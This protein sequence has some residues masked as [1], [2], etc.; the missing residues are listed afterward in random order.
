MTKKYMRFIRGVSTNAYGKTGVILTTSAAVSFFLFEAARLVGFFH[1]SYVGL[2]SYLLFPAVFLAGLALIPFGWYRLRKTT[3]RSTRELLATSFDKTDLEG[4]IFGSNVFMTIALLSLSNVIILGG[5]TT[6]MLSFMDEA[7]FCGTACHVM[8]PEWTVYQDSPHARVKC[9]ECH[10]GEGVDALISSK[11]NGMRQ[12]FLASFSIYNR[13]IPTPVHT[14]RPARET[15]E[16]CHWPDKFYGS[17][18]VNKV[19]YGMDS[20]S[21]PAYTTLNLKVD[22]GYAGNKAGI[23]WH[24]AKENEVRYAALGKKREKML[25]VDVRQPDGS[26][27][28]FV[29][30]RY[31]DTAEEPEEVR[32]LDCVDCHNRA[33]HIYELP[34]HE[35]DRLIERGMLDRSLPFIKRESLAALI[36]NYPDDATAANNIERHIAE[37]YV[38]N[39]R[40][41]TRGNLAAVDRA[42]TALQDVYARNVHHEMNIEWGTYVNLLGHQHRDAGCFRCHNES[43]KADDGSFIRNDCT[44]CHSILSYDEPEPFRYLQPVDPDDKNAA[45][46]QY[47]REEFLRGR[48]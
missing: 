44:L 17:R 38:R 8:N 13:P 24:V 48:K 41:E 1:N 10:V 14:L 7:E 28:R 11:L 40:D 36:K 27:R 22:A 33:T 42:V 32:T 20:S 19:S 29:N 23:H 45:M 39:F 16:K 12:M 26:F 18:L 35:V 6:Q 43:M 4:G 3:G 47:L 5:L 46:H 37:F 30:E 9:V 15:C 21:T 25:Y 2:I 34:E 31:A